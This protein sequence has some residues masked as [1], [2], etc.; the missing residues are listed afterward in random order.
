MTSFSVSCFVSLLLII[1][2]PIVVHSQDDQS[3]FISI[4]CGIPEN[5]YFTD[6]RTSLNYVSDSGF[7]DAGESKTILLP[8]YDTST[9]SRRLLTVRSFPRGTRNCYKL[10]P[11]QGP[12]NRYLIRA[13]F[14]YG[15]Y[16]SKGQAPKFD[17]HLGVEKW[18]TITFN[19]MLSRVLRE[20]IHVPTSEYIH[21]CLVNFGQ[22]LPIINALE[23][24]SVKKFQQ[25]Q[26]HD[27]DASSMMDIKS[28]YK[29]QKGNWQGD[30]CRPQTYAWEGIECSYTDSD[31]PRITSL[32]LSS[33]GL[34]GKIALSIANLTM[35]RSLDM[36]NNFL[37]GEIPDF[38][39]QLTFL[40]ILNIKGN[41]FTGS[42]PSDL[43]LKYKSGLLLLSTDASLGGGDTN[44]CLSSSCKKSS[45]KTTVQIAASVVSAFILIVISM[46]IIWWIVKRRKQ[47]GRS[48]LETINRRFTYSEILRITNNLEKNIGQGGF[49]TVYHGQIGNTQ[50]AVKM[51]SATSAQGYQEFQ[52]EARLLL[53]IHHK[54]LTALV[55]Y[56]DEDNHLGIIYEYMVNGDLNRFLTG[57]KSYVLSWEQRIHIAINA[58]EGFD[59]LHHGCKPP[60]IHRDIKSTN[61]LLTENF[62]GKV[63]DFGL[64]RIIPYEAAS[65]VTTE[66]AGTLG[67]LDPEYYRTSR[68]TEKTDVYSFGIVLLEIITARP[69]VGTDYD[70]EHIVKW[71]TSRIKEGDAKVIVDSRIRDNVDVSSVWKAVEIALM[72]VALASNDRPPMNFVAT[73]L[74]ES[75]TTDLAWDE[76][77]IIDLM[78]LNLSSDV[79]SPQAR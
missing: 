40:R 16:D 23:I 79:L 38:L 29:V 45:N 13:R 21:V 3:G 46:T 52:T 11:V 33:S 34:N 76:T 2:L 61:I 64:S 12:G 55:G 19:K 73:R 9:L 28:I 71:V 5:S 36:S 37:F 24:F 78:S 47:K 30:P 59:Y 15:N 49:G 42:I 48:S 57:R 39:S 25:S 31:L 67:Y 1:C 6:Q 70:R 18:D 77:R 50:V 56:C 69:A 68:L 35:I 60:I 63:A 17:I 53:R 54:N 32:N 43:L 27:Q 72:C 8:T 66:V 22:T 20:I 41:N 51:L 74:I 10:K 14:M 26:T 75:L 62:Q 7:T 44:Q 58:A 65:H 4:D